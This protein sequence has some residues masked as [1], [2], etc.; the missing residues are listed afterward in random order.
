M[1]QYH[2]FSLPSNENLFCGI[3]MTTSSISPFST[4]EIYSDNILKHGESSCAV[5]S[6]LHGAH[7]LSSPADT[8]KSESVVF[9]HTKLEGRLTN[10]SSPK[11]QFAWTVEKNLRIFQ[12]CVVY[13][14][15]NHTNAFGQI[16]AASFRFGL[17]DLSNNCHWLLHRWSRKKRGPLQQYKCLL[18]SIFLV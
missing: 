12:K 4:L 5:P 6:H 14:I 9:L 7:W 13:W 10:L 16:T 1:Q 18:R 8:E 17:L 3:L 15:L 2:V 11:K